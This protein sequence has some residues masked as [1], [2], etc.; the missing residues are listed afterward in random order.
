M[1]GNI[2]IVIKKSSKVTS[3]FKPDF[4]DELMLI[5]EWTIKPKKPDYSYE[6]FVLDSSIGTRILR[7]DLMYTPEG[8]ET[9]PHDGYSYDN[10]PEDFCFKV[11]VDSSRAN[12]ETLTAL[13]SIYNL[14]NKQPEQKHT[15]RKNDIKKYVQFLKNEGIVIE[16]EDK[17]QD[18]NLLFDVWTG[19]TPDGLI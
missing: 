3:L 13:V 7:N 16:E 2:R 1:K 18:F 4:Q 5:K 12:F 11:I 8:P 15:F 14:S 6:L 19:K 10:G 17:P 9:S